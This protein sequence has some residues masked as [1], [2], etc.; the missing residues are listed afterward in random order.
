MPG[1]HLRR[2][3]PERDPGLGDAAAHV[4]PRSGDRQPGDHRVRLPGQCGQHPVRI[5]GV[6]RLAEQ[7]SIGCDDDGV[8]TD[9]R[10]G[11]VLRRDG[12]RLGPRVL[13]RDGAWLAVCALVDRRRDDAVGDTELVQDRGA[14]GRCTRQH[15]LHQ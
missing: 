12:L 4:L 13:L 7:R 11:T 1:D 9:H 14:L 5:I 8:A 2:E 3:R 10:R 15:R 6:L